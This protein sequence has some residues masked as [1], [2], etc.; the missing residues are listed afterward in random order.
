MPMPVAPTDNLVLDSTWPMV[1]RSASVVVSMMA[2]PTPS[3]AKAARRRSIAA[4]P[5]PTVCRSI[6]PTR[7][8]LWRPRTRTRSASRIGLSG[9]SL[10]GLS[11]SRRSPTNRWPWYTVRRFSGKDGLTRTT[12]SPVSAPKASV[13]GPML[14]RSVESKVEQTFNRMCSAPRPSSH[15]APAT[16]VS[17]ARAG[18][19]ERLFR[20]TTT[21]STNGRAR[22]SGGTPMLWTVPR[23][24]RVR[25]LARSEAPV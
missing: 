13:T 9:W 6:S 3:A 22:P 12:R 4:Q 10:S 11:C 1:S 14:P 17:T 18:S 21:A 7:L 23:P 16:E 25:A 15:L 20:A 19:I 8:R 2:A 24:W 5:L